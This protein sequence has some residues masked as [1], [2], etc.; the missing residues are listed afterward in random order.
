[1][2]LF[3][4]HAH[5]NDEQFAAD[6][7][8]VLASARAAGVETILN[9][10]YDLPASRAAAALAAGR[11]GLYAAVG[12]HPH[13]AAGYD[14][15]AEKELRRLARAEKVV[16]IGEIGLDYYRELSPRPTQA[17]AFR[18]QIRLARALRLPIVV[19][20][21]EAHEDTLR[22]LREERASEVGGILH[23][24]SGSWEMA[25]QC[26]DLGFY[27]SLAG[28]VTFRNAVRP[29]EVARR[30][31]ADRLL[32]ETDAPYLAPEPHRGRRN[33][34]AFVALTLR[35]IAALREVPAEELAE[36]T[37]QNACRVLGLPA[38]N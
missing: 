33:E 1:M 16:A 5:L 17:E 38:G 36:Q 29:R 34:P 31:P 9:V 7:P 19:H 18:R 37:Y 35:A 10:G 32:V 20:D 22:I 26:L 11:P 30:V 4:S 27:I 28:P 6:L 25:R 21:R 12:I 13:D 23:C 8:A 14:E 3:D 15:A 24:F 2:R